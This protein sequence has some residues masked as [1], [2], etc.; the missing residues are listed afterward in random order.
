MQTPP[1]L[2]EGD[3]IAIVAP[4]KKI[5]A[6]RIENAVRIFESWGLRVVTGRN[7][8]ASNHYFAGTDEERA[9]DFQEMLDDE[10]VK[11]IICARGGYGTVRIIDMLD[12]S[13]F[14]K[15]PKWIVGYSDITV[16]HSHIARHF[17]VE[18]IHAPMPL[19]YPKEKNDGSVEYLRK[20]L[21][22]EQLNF[23]FTTDEASREGRT[24]AE[25]VGGNLSVLYSLTGSVSDLDTD[26]RILFLEEVG[27]NLYHLDRMMWSLKRAGKFRN[28]RALIIG[29]L[30][31]MKDN[32]DTTAF[33]K[34]SKEIIT[35]VIK[36]YDFPVCYGFP[37]GH[38]KENLAFIHGR[39]VN[40][41]ADQHKSI[42]YFLKNGSAPKKSGFIKNLGMITLTIAAF[43]L[44]IYL[45]YYLAIKF[46]T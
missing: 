8:L 26:N 31:G 2:R 42:L 32:N 4:A 5:A 22:G 18:T 46:L 20:A 36:D 33:G 16:L 9:A 30:S 7:L 40:L 38:E 41:S 27:E 28:I 21:F 24:E 3:K 35:E 1:Y 11:A 15:Y 29:H 19:D 34:T 17:E 13:V 39:R 23:E 14:S 44:I 45:L 25:I 43:F 37:A 6:E 10:S 12:F